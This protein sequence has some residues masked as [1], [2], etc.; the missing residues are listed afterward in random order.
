MLIYRQGSAVAHPTPQSLQPY[1]AAVEG[2][3]HFTIGLN[4]NDNLDRFPYTFAPLVYATMLL[5]SGHVLG[6][7]KADDVLGAF[8][9]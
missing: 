6:V 5:V 3:G 7:P 1:V 4:M 2:S 9:A 8:E